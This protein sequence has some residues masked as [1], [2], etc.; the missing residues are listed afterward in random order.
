MPPSLDLLKAELLQPVSAAAPCGEDCRYDERFERLKAEISKLSGV[1][2]GVANWQVIDQLS[3][4]LLRESKD[5]NLGA[6]VAMAW[7]NAEKAVGLV[8]GME[9]MTGLIQTFWEGLYPQKPKPRGIC[10]AWYQEKA[11]ASLKDCQSQ[12]RALIE[13][14]LEASTAL[15]EAVYERFEEPP[16]NFRGIHS[17]LEE[18]L[19]AAP[20]PKPA[21][22]PPAPAAPVSAPAPAPP[23]SAP[24]PAP[25]PAPAPSAPVAS[26]APSPALAL[27]QVDGSSMAA[28]ADH[29]ASLAEQMFRLDPFESLGCLLRR[30]GL[31]HGV[32]EPRH[33]DRV[34]SFPDPDTFRVDALIEMRKSAQWSN[35]F[36]RVEDLFA[37]QWYWLD[38]QCY[39]AV[40]AEGMNRPDLTRIVEEQALA[41]DE[42]LPN[43]KELRFTGGTP[44][45]NAETKDWL[46]QLPAK[47][48]AGGGG[49][50]DEAA[51]LMSELRKL[52]RGAF[53]EAMKLAQT[54]VESAR[55]GRL[56]FR[57]RAKVAAFCLEVDQ[58]RW[59]Q[60]LAQ[61]LIS[62]AETHRLAYW[63]PRLAA[64]AWSVQL[65]VARRFNE[66]E[67][68]RELEEQA[69]QQLAALDLAAAAQ[70]PFAD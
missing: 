13:R 34:T 45:A 18:W 52:G 30:L 29:L 39:A 20:A 44:F 31:W 53:A 22:P 66:L 33:E 65:E 23:S 24:S 49:A 64:E 4:A 17:A 63:E 40:A 3:T 57:M 42:R 1:A 69:M 5:L 28:L 61:A 25:T 50:P 36:T 67:R 10:L 60:S 19:A 41:L 51:S 58:P 48:S 32:G 14:G 26:S 35:L 54:R 12:D 70:F 15:K 21:E 56:A 8:V 16:A 47:L 11:L 46:A 43:L 9:L 2:S 59:A 38:L 37:Q 68:Y 27:P 6:Y 62:E 55:D 7:I